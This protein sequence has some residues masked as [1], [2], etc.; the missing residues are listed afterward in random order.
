MHLLVV[1][2]GAYLI[3]KTYDH[4]GRKVM[5]HPPSL[6][7][8]PHR[9]SGLSRDA[10]SK[11]QIHLHAAPAE[12][13][14]NAQAAFKAGF[15]WRPFVAVT[16]FKTDDGFSVVMQHPLKCVNLGGVESYSQPDTGP[17]IVP[18]E[19]G[20]HA[21]PIESLR[22]AYVAHNF[23]DWAEFLVKYPAEIPGGAKVDHFGTT[24]R[25]KAE[26]ELYALR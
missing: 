4:A 14:V 26:N 17:L 1:V 22:L 13:M 5:F 7:E 21:D 2:T 11:L 23:T 3:L 12:R 19:P 9:Q 16:R 8:Q 6:G 10:W 25:V 15:D 18:I 24:V 20:K